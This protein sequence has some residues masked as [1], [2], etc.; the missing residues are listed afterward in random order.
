MSGCSLD[1]TGT[2]HSYCCSPQKKIIRE[3]IPVNWKIYRTFKYRTKSNPIFLFM[4]KFPN[5][6]HRYSN[7]FCLKKEKSFKREKR[8]IWKLR[9]PLESILDLSKRFLRS[10]LGLNNQGKI[11]SLSILLGWIILWHTHLDQVYI[12]IRKE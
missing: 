1:S 3:H 7:Y 5:L 12:A 10:H 9:D 6:I 8:K 2:L 11:S 4:L